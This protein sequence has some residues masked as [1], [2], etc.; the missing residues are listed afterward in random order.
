MEDGNRNSARSKSRAWI[1]TC[2]STGAPLELHAAMVYLV[3]QL[4]QA[5]GTGRLHYQLYFELSRRVMLS[6]ITGWG[7]TWAHTHL[8]PRR[9][10][11]QQAIA[12][13]TKAESRVLGPWQHGE[14][15]ANEQG[16]RTD[17]EEVKAAVDSGQGWDTIWQE[18]FG[19]MVRS[20]KAI[21]TY[22]QV[23]GKTEEPKQPRVYIFWGHTGSGKTHRV[24]EEATAR[25]ASS[26]YAKGVYSHIY[27]SGNFF[28]DY[29]GQRI[30][31]FDEFTGQLD[32][33]YILRLT[34]KWA[35]KV[36]VKCGHEHWRADTIYFC[37]NVPPRRWWPNAKSSQLAAFRRRINDGGGSVEF[38]K[39]RGSKCIANFGDSWETAEGRLDACIRISEVQLEPVVAAHFSSAECVREVKGGDDGF[40]RPLEDGSSSKDTT[41]LA[42]RDHE[43]TKLVAGRH[44]PDCLTFKYHDD[45]V[46]C[47]TCS[48]NEVDIDDIAPCS[49]CGYV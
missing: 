49:T 2:F 46:V 22:A 18:H 38:Y 6:T 42:D 47:E 14:P 23:V 31:L 35:C 13:C 37:S 28:H 34:D 26:D 16:R 19:T 20:Y 45:G 43:R 11:Q 30:A 24:Y 12:Y 41:E 27:T 29:S 4:E 8:E 25:A 39:A 21:I 1:G 33:E 7:G 9:G 32:I 5:P 48:G 44:V 36:N 3:Y 40:V 17:L 15:I 10:S